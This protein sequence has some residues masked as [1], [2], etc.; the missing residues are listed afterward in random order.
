MVTAAKQV[1]IKACPI[2]TAIQLIGKK[3]T[4]LVIRD[5][6][7][8]L[9]RFNQFLDSI[10]GLNA[11]TLAIRLKEMEKNG[12]IERRVVTSSPIHTEYTLTE[13]GRSLQP[14]LNAMTTFSIR[15]CCDKMFS[16][17]RPRSFEEF[18][19][20]VKI[21]SPSEYEAWTKASASAVPSYSRPEFP[22]MEVHKKL[23]KR[24]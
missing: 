22:P 16:D 24:N 12:L 23:R 13:K 17:G 5:I 20:I 11:K 18:I 10:P 8:G 9:K 15:W 1:E 4:V 14:I 6:V 19:R 2:D 7:R 21:Q 3:W